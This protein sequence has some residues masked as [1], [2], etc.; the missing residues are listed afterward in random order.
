MYPTPLSATRS[1]IDCRAASERNTAPDRTNDFPTNRPTSV[2]NPAAADRELAVP[3]LHDAV[4]V[5]LRPSGACP[6]A[7]RALKC[8]LRGAR[9]PGTKLEN[10]QSRAPGLQIANLLLLRSRAERLAPP[11]YRRLV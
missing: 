5:I 11:A 6:R 3:V 8:R 2:P 1:T 4:A 7:R 10:N 9:R